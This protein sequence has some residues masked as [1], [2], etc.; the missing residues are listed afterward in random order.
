MIAHRSMMGVAELRAVHYQPYHVE[1]RVYLLGLVAALTAHP[2]GSLFSSSLPP[3]V[4]AFLSFP[5]D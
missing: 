2:S 4:L 1:N 3:A 5:E